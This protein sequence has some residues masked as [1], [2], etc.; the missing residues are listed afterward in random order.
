MGE[1]FGALA[2]ATLLIWLLSLWISPRLME[3]RHTRAARRRRVPGQGAGAYPP[4]PR[5]G[6]DAGWLPNPVHVN[7]QLF[8]NGS[9]WAGRRRWM[10]GSGWVEQT[11]AHAAG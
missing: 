2:A 7:E 11:P 1:I 9:E 4:P 3:G 5:G 10:P 6:K 8:W